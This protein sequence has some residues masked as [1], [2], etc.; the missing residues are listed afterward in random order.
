M[1]RARTRDVVSEYRVLQGRSERVDGLLDAVTNPRISSHDLPAGRQGARVRAFV[2][3]DARSLILS[4]TALPGEGP[5]T[6][7]WRTDPEPWIDLGQVADPS[8]V[9][10]GA[11]PLPL[12]E[13]LNLPAALRIVDAAST[14]VIEG[15][16]EPPP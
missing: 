8:A 12:P 6:V 14:V 1:E 4:I 7:Q 9:A 16:L 11:F 15:P 3:L 10:G 2:D 5:F 13:G